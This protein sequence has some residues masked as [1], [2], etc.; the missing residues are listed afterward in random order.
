MD[1]GSQPLLAHHSQGPKEWC[2]HTAP[3]IPEP[4][5]VWVKKA[6]FI[7]PFRILVFRQP[8]LTN[9]T[10]T[11]SPKDVK[12][13]LPN[14]NNQ[15]ATPWENPQF[16]ERKTHNLCLTKANT[17]R[18]IF[19][20]TQT[21]LK[22]PFQSELQCG[23]S[24]S[25]PQESSLTQQLLM[26]SKGDD[27]KS[28]SILLSLGA[29][30]AGVDMN[31]WTALHWA[32]AANSVTSAKVLIGHGAPLEAR[33][34]KRVDFDEGVI[35]SSL[36]PLHL[37]AVVGSADVVKILLD[38]GANLHTTDNLGGT[39]YSA[40]C[41]WNNEAVAQVL[42]QANLKQKKLQGPESPQTPFGS[43]VFSKTSPLVQSCGEVGQN[44][45]GPF[46]TMAM[47]TAAA[48]QEELLQSLEPP[49][50]FICPV[51]LHL[52]SDPVLLL[53][54]Q[55]TYD[56]E[57]IEKWFRQGHCTCPVTR[58]RLFRTEYV[59]NLAL[60]NAIEEWM[61]LQLSEMK[62]QQGLVQVPSDSNIQKLAT[63]P[64][65]S[66]TSPTTPLSFYA[67]DGHIEQELLR[68]AG[69]NDVASVELLLACGV[70]PDACDAN[71]W[72]SLHFAASTNSV[73]V[74]KVLILRKASLEAKTTEKVNID[75]SVWAESTPLHVAAGF[76][77]S[78]VA[79]LLLEAGANPR[80]CDALGG[81]PLHSAC[82]WG[83]I[84]IVQALIEAGAD[85]AAITN[86]KSSSSPL[87]YAARQGHALV[88]QILI[89][90]LAARVQTDPK[91]P[92]LSEYVNGKNSNKQTALHLAAFG[93]HVQVVEMLLCNCGDKTI[94]N[95]S[96]KVPGQ[97]ICRGA[98][99]WMTPVAL[100]EVK[101]H[102]R[103]L[104]A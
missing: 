103:G 100:A 44:C 43:Q 61:E 59:S 90:S 50:S 67:Q 48:Q 18:Q 38:A 46:V 99:N 78:E 3:P 64:L 91:A 87:H 15:T 35:W 89:Q 76:Q 20:S 88:A 12:C 21:M 25:S 37:A 73:D 96:G 24:L 93:G 19:G 1:F 95:K 42:M 82:F 22:V 81:T 83:N 32:A 79:R 54:T 104:L 52:M 17:P 92:S 72:T 102:L 84:N 97:L 69:L 13:G 29:S 4:P 10:L 2:G 75:G 27:S 55:Q 23:T 101:Q 8:L 74:V 56:R 40:A 57:S 66:Q 7:I 34:F 49:P 26:A 51:S 30:A 31:G 94:K 85:V 77:S 6:S 68:A 98:A 65:V 86:S 16:F 53:E 80:S 47:R 5:F 45:E 11:H 28:V 58:K 71:G 60:R 41:F 33:T 36:T 9:L 62:K 70:S 63:E 14:P 39:P